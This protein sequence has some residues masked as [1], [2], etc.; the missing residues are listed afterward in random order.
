MTS[1]KN[2]LKKQLDKSFNLEE[3]RS[4]CFELDIDHEHLPNAIKPQLIEA[5][6]NYLIRR[7]RLLDLIWLV[8]VKRPHRLWPEPPPKKPLGTDNALNPVDNNTTIKGKVIGSA[9]GSGAVVQADVI[10]GGDVTVNNFA[11]Y[12]RLQDAYIDPTPIL[13]KVELANFVGREWLFEEV[14]CFLRQNP[15]GYF[16][17]EGEAGIG[18]TTFLAKLVSERQYIHHF[19]DLAPGKQGLSAAIQCL[20]VQL[21]RNYQISPYSEMEILPNV[22]GEPY[23]LSNLLISAVAHVAKNEKIIL[24]VDA[25]DKAGVPEQ[26][27]PLGLPKILPSNV[28]IIVSSRLGVAFQVEGDTRRKVYKLNVDSNENQTDLSKYI[29]RIVQQDKFKKIIRAQEYYPHDF[30]QTL[31][32][33]SCGLWIYYIVSKI[34]LKIA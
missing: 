12:G 15:N 6:L 3:I 16:I 1:Y 8:R 7:N 29:H 22:A 19:V 14:D 26:Q 31:L 13:D 5:L 32:K 23:F 33:K 2:T 4:L 25:I 18:K 17:L 24:I 27:N 28:Y 10:A 21:I 34:T 11:N 9:T 30:V 20:G